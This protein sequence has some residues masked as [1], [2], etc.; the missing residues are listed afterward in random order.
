MTKRLVAIGAAVAAVLPAA[1][2]ALELT[3]PALEDGG[4]LPDAYVFSGMGCEGGSASPPLAWSGAPDGTQSFALT[5]YDPD[6]PT[7]SGWWHWVVANIP[8]DVTE[9]AEGAS[10]GGLP[11]GALET[12]TDFGAPGF[13]G[14]CPPPGD[15]PHRYIFTIH[16]LGVDSLPLE[17]DMSGAMAGFYI[18]ANAVESASLT[19]TF[20][21]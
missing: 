18:H 16:A 21:R 15:E 9:L 20:G 14:A 11:D 1:A 19:V 5:V 2:L 17:A 3:S 12:R 6:A 4:T 7:G 8:S 10:A 13:G